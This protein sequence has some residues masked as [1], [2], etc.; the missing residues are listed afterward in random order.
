M[1][2]LLTHCIIDMYVYILSIDTILNSNVRVIGVLRVVYQNS[3][4]LR[5]LY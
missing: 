4:F 5:L 3:D 1:F 2:T